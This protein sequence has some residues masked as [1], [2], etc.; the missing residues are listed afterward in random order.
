[1]SGGNDWGLERQ[2]ER[3]GGRMM[4]WLLNIQQA[5]KSMQGVVGRLL[6]YGGAS[7]LHLFISL[8]FPFYFSTT[9][10]QQSL[11]RCPLPV[12]ISPFLTVLQF[13]PDSFFIFSFF[14]FPICHFPFSFL[15]LY[16]LVCFHS[17]HSLT[18]VIYYIFYFFSFSCNK[19]CLFFPSCSC[20][21]FLLIS[22]FQF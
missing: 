18:C 4:E 1:M 9:A 2:R 15:C 6:H 12:S 13:F 10:S 21:C 8:F 5:A 3:K 16:V 7:V 17:F 22:F 14:K 19:N 11:V 20:Y